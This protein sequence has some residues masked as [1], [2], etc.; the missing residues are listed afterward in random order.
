[1]CLQKFIAS[2]AEAPTERLPPKGGF[3]SKPLF[4]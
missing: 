2:L 3:C 1:M 4:L